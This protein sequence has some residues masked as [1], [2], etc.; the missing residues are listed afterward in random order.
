M[1]MNKKAI[2]EQL[3]HPQLQFGASDAGAHITQQAGSGDS[4]ALLETFV[5]KEKLLGLEFAI[6]KQTKD[7]AEQFH[8][9]DR[10]TIEVGK[11]ADLVLFDLEKLEGSLD[12]F[13][14]DM[15]GNQNRYTRFAKG[16]S[17]VWVNGTQVLEN[18]EYCADIKGCGQ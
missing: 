13:A 11:A 6:E 8:M 12:T 4:T 14:S 7:L 3:L 1:N 10:G 2:A 17:G 5:K 16:Y 15:P 9:H 18:D